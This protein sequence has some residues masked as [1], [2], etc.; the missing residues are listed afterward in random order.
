MRGS[1]GWTG[2]AMIA[3]A[4]A[5][6]VAAC[7]P[8][9]GGEPGAD[10]ADAPAADPRSPDAEAAT[11]PDAPSADQA[12]TPAQD[13]GWIALFDGTD[14]SA[15]RGY[16]RADVPSAWQVR[17]GLL[18]LV[19]GDDG[20]DL[21]TREEFGDFELELS[22]RVGPGGNSGVFYRA[23]EEPEIIWHGA[24]ELQILDDAGHA[25]GQAAST[26]AGALYDLYPP[27]A[28]VVRPAGEWNR[29]RV[30]A[31]GPHVEHWLNGTKIV[32]YE[33]GSE[34]WNQRVEASKFA[35]YPGF[36][37]AERGHIGIQ[38]HGDPV[39]FRDIRVRPGNR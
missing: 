30:V 10:G 14:L 32:E 21:V 1:T 18:T 22:W 13:T 17:D 31:R 15:W 26:S 7:A 12:D 28:D 25:D 37:E 39:E 11:M 33:V 16:R 38:D 2:A 5:L 24:P 29:I 8:P 6:G 27:T 36:G 20:G 3:L 23:T 4:T 34:D 19:P 9:G 35:V